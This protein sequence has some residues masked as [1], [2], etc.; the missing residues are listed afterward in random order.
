MSAN[1][2]QDSVDA[3]FVRENGTNCYFLIKNNHNPLPQRYEV[4]KTFQD[5]PGNLVNLLNIPRPLEENLSILLKEQIEASKYIDK[6]S[7]YQKTVIEILEG[8]KK[9]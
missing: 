2:K 5:V 3:L 9:R 7:G 8:S 1:N 4:V 6:I